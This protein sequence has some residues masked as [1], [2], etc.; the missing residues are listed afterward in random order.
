MYD[1]TVEECYCPFMLGLCS[2][3][4]QTSATSCAS[5]TLLVVFGLCYLTL[6]SGCNDQDEGSQSC[7]P[8]ESR[9]CG[10]GCAGVKRCN[11]Y[12]LWGDCVCDAEATGTG[13]ASLGQDCDDDTNCP[14]SATCLQPSGSAWLGGG[15]PRGIC[16]ADCTANVDVCTRFRNARCVSSTRAGGD[17][18][19]SAVCMP[20][21]D[22]TAG[23]TA[24]PACASVPFSACDNLN[25]GTVG[26]CRPFCRVDSD[27]P[28]AHCDRQVG[29]CIAQ[30]TEAPS[31]VFGESCE[32][33][34]ADCRGV[35]LDLG[36]TAAGTSAICSH[37]CTFGTHD[38]C[39]VPG[40]FPQTAACV[41]AAS[42]S[43]PGDIG[44]CAPLCDC[45]DDCLASG[46]VC[47]AFSTANSQNALG[48]KGTCVPTNSAETGIPCT[49]GN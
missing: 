36:P 33:S 14:T 15:P 38:D 37:R 1:A 46:F 20:A 9:E 45:N 30:L 17:D 28:T 3:R 39:S 18:T 41:Y 2:S 49:K 22:L 40:T 13:P 25:E 31:V 4:T 8:G 48:R 47:R 6:S 42:F 43:Y 26:F 23:T 21:C 32:P 12:G 5:Q 29:V 24:N 16:V 34:Q 44:Y 19:P 35:C 27:C 7:A 11:D 10:I